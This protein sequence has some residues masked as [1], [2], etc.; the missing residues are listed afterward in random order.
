M[1]TL[2]TINIIHPSGTIN[3][4]V[5]DSSGNITVG[6]NLTVTGT[7]ALINNVV[8]GFSGTG[9]IATTTLTISAVASGTLAVGSVISGTGV[10]AGTT[11]TAILTG[12]G[13]VGTYTV[14]ASQ[15]VSST[16]ITAGTL[17][18]AGAS[19]IAAATAIG[20]VPFST[21]GTTFTPTQKITQGT[22]VS[23]ATTSFTASISGTTMTVTAVASGTIA[24][25]QVITGTGVT[26]GTVI[27]AR[28]TGTGGTGTYTV[29]ASQTVA[30]T[31][32]TIVGVDFLSIPSWV[33]RVTVMFNGVST[34]GTSQVQVQVG[35]G[36]VS[37]TG[38]NCAVGYATNAGAFGSATTGFILEGT[39]SATAAAIRYGSLII[40]L[41]GS[42]TYV[43]QLCVYNTVATTNLAG[44]GVS[45]ALSGALDRVRITTVGGTDTFDAGS[46]NILY[47]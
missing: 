9:S 30:S 29:S 42:N 13:G 41:I 12:S 31:T 36:S 24:V 25:G 11:I 32:I 17:T 3:N 10:T 19:T 34:N 16:T 8:V 28:G 4:I 39:G 18:V 23:T 33:K 20:Q 6:N 5:N 21:D 27:T 1:S 14:S 26:A 44:S 45:P 38:Y 47:E 35:S 37:T 2:K 7:S 22:T 46:I 15:T 40:S 43:G